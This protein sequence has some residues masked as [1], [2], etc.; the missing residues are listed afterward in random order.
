MKDYLIWIQSGQCIEGTAE[1]NE[2]DNL[3]ENWRNNHKFFRLYDSTGY[4]VINLQSVQAVAVNNIEQGKQAGF[5]VITNIG[6]G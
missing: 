5:A 6:E 3:I 2:L 4:I 1:E